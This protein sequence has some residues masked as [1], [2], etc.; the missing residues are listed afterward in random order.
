V[1]HLKSDI[2][3]NDFHQ[4]PDANHPVYIDEPL[5]ILSLMTLFDDKQ[6]DWRK[7]QMSHL[8]R[9]ASDRSSQGVRLEELLLMVLV[10]NFGGKYTA[11]GDVFSFCESS[12]LVSRMVSLVSLKRGDGVIWSSPVSWKTGSSDRLGFKAI[13]PTDVLKFLSDPKGRPFLFP[14]NHMGPDLMCFFEDKE[15]GE[16][17]MVAVQSKITSPLG[18]KLWIEAVNSVTPECFYTMAKDGQKMRYAPLSY[19]YLAE[20][21]ENLLKVVLGEDVY[22]PVVDCYRN[23]L[24]SSTRH[25][26]EHVLLPKRQTP[27]LLRVVATPDDKQ[28]ERLKEGWGDPV[29]VLKWDV[30]KGYLGSTADVLTTEQRSVY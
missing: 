15:T 13:S 6:P 24:R 19:P 20:E 28:Q 8:L 1:G 7:K 3:A 18:S 26:E 30:V 25:K 27:R 2:T 9:T 29:A 4:N 11:L 16:L 14:D 21:V 10:E 23:K 12:P 22:A 17:I 5:I